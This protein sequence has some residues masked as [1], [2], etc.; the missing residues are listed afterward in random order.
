MVNLMTRNTD[1]IWKFFTQCGSFTKNEKAE[2]NDRQWLPASR[3]SCLKST[4]IIITIPVT[5]P[6][7]SP[8][9]AVAPP[10]RAIAWHPCKVARNK[11]VSTSKWPMW[12]LSAVGSNPEM[13]KQLIIAKKKKKNH[14]IGITSLH[15]QK[16][17][18]SILEKG[19]LKECYITCVNNIWES[20]HCFEIIAGYIGWMWGGNKVSFC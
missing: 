10:I 13:M 7:G 17:S 9:R 19:L 4:A 16:K 6:L 14:N 11:F 1:A 8:T 15:I 12:R 2:K 20:R 5:W 18:F 3:Q